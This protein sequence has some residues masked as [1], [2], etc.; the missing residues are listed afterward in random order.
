MLAAAAAAAPPQYG[1]APS[2]TNMNARVNRHRSCP[3]EGPVDVLLGTDV[4]VSVESQSSH[5]PGQEHDSISS[6]ISKD[7]A[8]DQE[9][10]T[11]VRFGDYIVAS[12]A[13][14]KDLRSSSPHCIVCK[15]ET[16]TNVARTTGSQQQVQQ[17]QYYQSRYWE[18]AV[19]ACQHCEDN[20]ECLV[21]SGCVGNI[22]CCSC[23]Q[24][25]VAIQRY[26][27]IELLLQRAL[28]RGYDIRSVAPD[29]A[30]LKRQIQ[31]AFPEGRTPEHE[32]VVAFPFGT[33]LFSC[34]SAQKAE[35]QRLLR[36][37][38]VEP[39][40]SEF[41]CPV[42]DEQSFPSF[43]LM[44]M[45]QEACCQNMNEDDF[46]VCLMNGPIAFYLSPEYIGY[47]QD[48]QQCQ[49]VEGRKLALLN[50]TAL[51]L[52]TAGFPLVELAEVKKAQQQVITTFFTSKTL[53]MRRV[54]VRVTLQ[55][56][57]SRLL[58]S[59]KNKRRHCFPPFLNLP[60]LLDEEPRDTGTEAIGSQQ[61]H[62]SME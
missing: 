10:K 54:S 28:E 13:C 16:G 46:G 30:Q 36:G 38:F 62:G 12:T 23:E 20:Y 50:D 1:E 49:N 48:L 17:Q 41:I 58:N 59:W 26:G 3:D 25:A 6:V 21:C 52:Q 27:S 47:L 51:P 9:Q 39:P 40:V 33:M 43:L 32:R 37:L 42:C 60:F 19:V 34:I 57:V 5:G 55:D 8:R 24:K 53:A 61:S 11:S 31:K 7:P 29:K 44:K 2:R 4:L 15:Q 14:V 35:A 56:L 22:E 45:H 18:C